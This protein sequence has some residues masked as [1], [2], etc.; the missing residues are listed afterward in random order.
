MARRLT[1]QE[2]RAHVLA[3]MACPYGSKGTFLLEHGLRASAMY[4]W[5]SALYAG[6]LEQG[7][8]PRGGVMTTVEENQE[9]LRLTRENERLQERVEQA[10][11]AMEALGKAIALLQSQHGR[12]SDTTAG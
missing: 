3:H 2:K 9:I 7:L 8:I 5:R 6:S 4:E 11:Q 1:W 10:E 12:G